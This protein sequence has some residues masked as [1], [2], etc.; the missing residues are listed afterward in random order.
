METSQ[1]L[2]TDRVLVTHVQGVTTLTLNAPERLNALDVQ[3][4][5]TLAD[6]IQAPHEDSR[7]IVLRGA[8]RGFCTGANLS[9]SRQLAAADSAGDT[10]DAVNRVVAAIIASPVPVVAIVQ[11]P[12]AGVGVSIA[13]ASDIVIASTEAYFQLAFT[14]VGLMPD[15]GA[16]VLVAAA[17]GRATALRMALLADRIPAEHAWQLG[18]IARLA[19]ADQLEQTATQVIDLLRDGPVV[20]LANSKTAINAACLTQLEEAFQRERAG[21]L[22][23][24][25]AHDFQEGAQAFLEKRRARFRDRLERGDG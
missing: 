13:L 8:G 3:M 20:A 9:G 21:Q 25:A 16:T 24:L 7:V 12:C 18:L 22:A 4:L 19:P 14:R 6:L 11:G 17:L 2:D 10:L 1:D 15:G 5:T 23:L